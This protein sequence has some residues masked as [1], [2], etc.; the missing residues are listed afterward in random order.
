M[1]VVV[2]SSDLMDRWGADSVESGQVV[3][4]GSLAHPVVDHSPFPSHILAAAGHN[5]CH[6]QELHRAGQGIHEHRQ[7]LGIAAAVGIDLVVVV[8]G[9]QIVVVGDRGA[10]GRGTGSAVVEVADVVRDQRRSARL[11][12]AL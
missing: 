2:D 11:W 7:G 12:S 9:I 8:Q 6:S 4:L 10:E 1:L 5:P 3:G